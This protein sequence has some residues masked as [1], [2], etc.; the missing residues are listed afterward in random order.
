[1]LNTGE[2]STFPSFGNVNPPCIAT[3][4]LLRLMIRLS[5]WLFPTPVILNLPSASNAPSAS[6]VITPPTHQPHVDLSPSSLVM[7]L[8]LSPSSPSEISKASSQIDKKKKKQKEKKKKNQKGTKPPTTLDVG[9]KQLANTNCTGSVDEVDKTT[10]KNLKPKFPCSLCKG[11]HFLGDFPSLPK[12]LEMWSSMSSAPAGHS[13]D[14]PLTSDVKVGKKK[15][16]VE[17]PY[18]L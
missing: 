5:V 10:M 7:S 6:N 13:G 2:P 14:A 3:L 16:I 18:M 4:S 1:V 11:D 12:V 17:F 9:S 15:T 8:S